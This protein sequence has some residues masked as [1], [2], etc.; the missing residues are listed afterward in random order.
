MK[1]YKKEEEFEI[2]RLY[3]QVLFSWLELEFES[4]ISKLWI[5][6]PQVIGWGKMIGIFSKEQCTKKGL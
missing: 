3:V 1:Q 6:C 5:C 4:I 2:D